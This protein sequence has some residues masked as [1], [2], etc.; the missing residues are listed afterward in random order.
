MVP[1]QTTACSSWMGQSKLA[2][3]V[4]L[5]ARIR[6]VSGSNLGR[7]TI[8]AEI[9][10]DISQSLQTNASIV[11]QNRSGPFLSTYFLIDNRQVTVSFDAMQSDLPLNKS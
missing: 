10:S 3:V 8:V 5:L 4:T 1:Y 11:L 7:Y 6:K 9:C 2:Q